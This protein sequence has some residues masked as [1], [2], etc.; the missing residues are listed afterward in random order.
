MSSSPT[1]ASTSSVCLRA[2]QTAPLTFFPDQLENSVVALERRRLTRDEAAK[3]SR[4]MEALEVK[5][6]AP[7]NAADADLIVS[8]PSG[9]WHS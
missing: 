8:N 5:A 2:Y 4:A 1:V 9:L 3:A 7:V 6:P